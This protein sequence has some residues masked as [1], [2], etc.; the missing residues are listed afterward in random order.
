MTQSQPKH[1][2]RP[3]AVLAV[4][5][6]PQ[7]KRGTE[8]TT[9]SGYTA[10]VLKT[11]PKNPNRVLI[12]YTGQQAWLGEDSY[13]PYALTASFSTQHSALTDKEAPREQRT[14]S[15]NLGDRA[16]STRPDH[17][18]NR[19][20][21]R[22]RSCTCP[23][24][25]VQTDGSAENQAQRQPAGLS[26]ETSRVK[27]PVPRSQISAIRSSGWI[28]T[29][30]GQMLNPL[31]YEVLEYGSLSLNAQIE[32]IHKSGPVMPTGCWIE[33]YTTTRTLQNGTKKQYTYY[34]V[35]AYEPIFEAEDGTLKR[36]KSLG[37]AS[38]ATYQDWC[39]RRQ[40]RE[41]IAQLQKQ[42][43]H[44]QK[45]KAPPEIKFRVVEIPQAWFDEEINQFR[46][47][48]MPDDYKPCEI[49]RHYCKRNP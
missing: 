27:Q 35:K 10:K 33:S 47:D 25:P 7:L 4:K 39:Q 15:Q 14:A 48:P 26:L 20:P 41:R 11:D 22:R 38:S 23:T 36:S 42:L 1:R 18:R 44:E 34:R 32:A 9:P 8:V 5:Q 3:E 46:W 6:K 45:N 37:D 24:A 28:V 17:D 13:P 49:Y 31:H 40:R 16:K 21:S 43:K 19:H 30:D 2:R 29:I 12:R